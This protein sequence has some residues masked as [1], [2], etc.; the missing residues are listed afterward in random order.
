MT[1]W[2]MRASCL[3]VLLASAQAGLAQEFSADVVNN[4]PDSKGR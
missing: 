4:K 2:M 3:V 1:R